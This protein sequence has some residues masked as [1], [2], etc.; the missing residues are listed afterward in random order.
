MARDRILRFVN[1]T[2]NITTTHIQQHR[3]AQQAV[4]TGD[5]RWALEF[6]DIGKLS[7]WYRRAGR[8]HDRNLRERF[9]TAAKLRSVTHAHRKA[10]AAFDRY[11]EIRF[12]DAF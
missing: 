9:A 5:H 3:T 7:R 10:A 1:E 6:T 4:L 12:T 8:R 11:R 2:P